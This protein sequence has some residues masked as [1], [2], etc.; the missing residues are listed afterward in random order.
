M[1]WV[2]RH[3]RQSSLPL[4]VTGFAATRADHRARRTRA[5]R[6]GKAPPGTVYDDAV[7][8]VGGARLVL[9]SLLARP[10]T[11]QPSGVV[12]GMLGA[13]ALAHGRLVIDLPVGRVL[14]LARAFFQVMRRVVAV[15]ARSPAY[16]A[17]SPPP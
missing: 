11:P 5:A 9:E 4:C 6:V 2:Y 14:D 12:D 8:Y 15:R 13:D 10:S 1:Q 7:L 3:V 16:K 17:P